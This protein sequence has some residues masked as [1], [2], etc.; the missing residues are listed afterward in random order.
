MQV[1]ATANMEEIKAAFR[2]A[3]KKHH[4][5]VASPVRKITAL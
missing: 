1:P 5:D 3:A 2:V 4:P